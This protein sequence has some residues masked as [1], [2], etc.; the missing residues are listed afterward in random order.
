MKRAA[1][2]FPVD[3]SPRRRYRLYDGHADAIGPYYIRWSGSHDALGEEW[4]GAPFDRNGVLLAVP[5]RY[6]HATRIAQYALEQHSRWSETND[7]AAL[8]AF[9]AQARWL[10]ENQVE[11]SGVPGCYPFPLDWTTYGAKAGYISAMTQG[12]AI[13]VLLRAGEV[14]KDARYFEAAARAAASFRYDIDAGGVA[15]RDGGDL[16]F[17]EAASVPPSHILNGWIY[18]LWGLFELLQRTKLAWVQELYEESLAT[19]TRRLPLYDSGHWSYY[20]LLAAPNGFRKLATLKYHAFHIA[21]LHVLGSMT[22]D[23][24]FSD[25]ARRWESYAGVTA[26]RARVWLNAASAV[27]IHALGR[28]DTIPGGARPIALPPIQ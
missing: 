5:E 14:C 7:P 11:R 26:N 10:A 17:E 9:T 22:G 18:A 2:A 12:E 21:Q 4:D 20:S 16:Y 24:F 6:Y 25:T 3:W 15:W 23:K 28:A 1:R 13:S 8:K 19:L 27:A